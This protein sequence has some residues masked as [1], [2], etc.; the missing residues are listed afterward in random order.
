M[1]PMRGSFTCR[2]IR[3][4]MASRIASPTFCVRLVAIEVAP[5]LDVHERV[6]QLDAVVAGDEPLDLVEHLLRV[7]GRFGDAAHTDRAALPLVLIVDLGDGHV[8]LRAQ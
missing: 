2:W 1:N 5:T 4:P 8:E 3:S 6:E 7:E